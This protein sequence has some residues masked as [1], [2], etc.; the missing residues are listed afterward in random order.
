MNAGAVL[1]TG[2][3]ILQLPENVANY[4]CHHQSGAHAEQE[5]TIVSDAN[6]LAGLLQ[7]CIV[8]LK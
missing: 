4:L 2:Y 7:I 6:H 8:E 5:S 3:S 1:S